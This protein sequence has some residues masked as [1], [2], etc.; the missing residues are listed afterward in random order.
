[1]AL[2]GTTLVTILVVLAVA[3]P[4]LL[5]LAV[6]RISRGWLRGSVT[7]L[8]VLLSQVLAVGAAGL[9]A[10]DEFGFYNSWSD[11]LG[12]GDGA[13]QVTVANGL[14]PKDG[15]QGSVATLAVPLPSPHPGSA[16]T[17]SMNALVWLPREYAQ[18]AY[19]SAKFPVVMMLPGQPGTPPGVFHQFDFARQATLAIEQHRVKPFVA[20]FP[21]IMIAPPRDTECTDVAHGPQAESWLVGNVRSALL[22]S[23]RATPDGRQWSVMG[24]STGGFCAAKLLLRHPTEFHAAVGFGAYY[25]AETDRTT[26]NLFGGNDRLRRENSPLWLIQRPRSQPARLLIIVSRLDRAPDDGYTY[27][28]SKQMIEATQ[29]VPGV[30]TLVLP[31]GGHNYRVYRPTVAAALSWLGTAGCPVA[32]QPPA[33]PQG[34]APGFPRHCRAQQP[35]LRTGRPQAHGDMMRIARGEGNAGTSGDEDQAGE[36]S[37]R[38]PDV[39]GQLRSAF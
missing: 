6:C 29:G 13:P 5:A 7:V 22:R 21:P 31:Q 10:N 4:V 36:P 26:G 38:R 17:R 8:G 27:A 25:D 3:V 16:A 12:G 1:M 11:L 2:T 32:R 28:D 39:A 34:F 14:V 35:V 15:S 20:V 18:P 33:P 24:W 23:V 19:R 30:S 9:V 37:L